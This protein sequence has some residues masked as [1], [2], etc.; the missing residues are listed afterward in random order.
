MGGESGI[1]DND[2]PVVSRVA[3]LE[4]QMRHEPVLETIDL[5]K[6]AR[7]WFRR[8][9]TRLFS[10]RTYAIETSFIS[11]VELFKVLK[12]LVKTSKPFFKG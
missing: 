3:R 10:D 5:C 8:V 6:H 4:E 2:L 11:S 1:N 7:T 12:F 9:R